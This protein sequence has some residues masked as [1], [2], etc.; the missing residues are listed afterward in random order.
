M[1]GVKVVYCL[2]EAQIPLFNQVTETYTPACI[3]LG[4][5]YYQAKITSNQQFSGLGVIV[6][7]H[8]FA[9]L[10]F[11]LLIQEICLVYLLQIFLNGSIKSDNITPGRKGLYSVHNLL[12]R[13]NKPLT[14]SP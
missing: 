14:E 12:F 3:S 9:E 11:G 10:V 5:I 6:F 8:S 7:D 4:Y 2:Y 13:H 1:I